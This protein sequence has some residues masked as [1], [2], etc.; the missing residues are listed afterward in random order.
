MQCVHGLCDRPEALDLKARHECGFAYKWTGHRQ[1]V[2]IAA[3]DDVRRVGDRAHAAHED[4]NEADAA[5]AEL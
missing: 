3:R 1:Q 2:C 5:C 4:K